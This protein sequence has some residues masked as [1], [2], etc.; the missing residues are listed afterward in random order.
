MEACPPLRIVRKGGTLDR[1]SIVA[2]WL[3]LC[4]SRRMCG[5]VGVLMA[6]GRPAISAL[7]EALLALQHRGQDAAGIV[8]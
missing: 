4:A 3:A 5:I 8:T 1:R 7:Y 2:Q 6:E